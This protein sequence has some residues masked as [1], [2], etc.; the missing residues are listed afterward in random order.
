MDYQALC[1]EL[2]GTD[3]VAELQKIARKAK[4][5]RNAGR[6]RKFSAKQVTEME[7]MLASG[8]TINAVAKH[9]GTS[10]QVIDRYVNRPPQK[11]HT[12]RMTYMN[13]TNI[14][15]IIDV[16]FLHEKVMIKNR[17]EDILHR[18]FGVVEEPT[19]EQFQEFLKDRCF[20]ETRGNVKA[21]LRDMGLDCYDP[22]QIVEKTNGRTADDSLWIRFKY[23]PKGREAYANH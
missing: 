13:G 9:Y 15:T 6:K 12:L 3:D 2:F 23:Y 21:L 11:D 5:N 19:W 20:P 17:T 4:D 18:A 16:D 1:K 7:K 14:C 8:K 22:L 10:R